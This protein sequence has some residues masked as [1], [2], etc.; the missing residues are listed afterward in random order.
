MVKNKN[1]NKHKH[2]KEFQK[3]DQ[4]SL[5]TP[6]TVS[7]EQ[8]N[9]KLYNIGNT[10]YLNSALQCLL[11]NKLFIKNVREVLDHI[12]GNSHENLRRFNLLH[13]LLDLVENSKKGVAN[14]VSL[15]QMLAGYND[16]FKNNFQHDC[17]E[18]LVTIL[19]IIHEETKNLKLSERLYQQDIQYQKNDKA[20]K[21][22]Y[23][24]KSFKD[25]F[26]YSFVT[27]LFSGQFVSTTFCTE[28]RNENHN[29]EIFNSITLNIPQTKRLSDGKVVSPDIRDSFYQYFKGE[30]LEDRIE[31]DNCPLNHDSTKKRTIMK[32]RLSVWR[33]PRI[34]ILTLKRYSGNNS[35]DNSI[36]EINNIIQ[37]QIES[38]RELLIYDLKQIVNHEGSSPNR[39]HY[40]TVVID[41]DDNWTFVDDDSA[42]SFG[43]RRIKH[44][45]T[46]YILMYVARETN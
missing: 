10:C 11:N 9:I 25:I 27:H 18:C 20:L 36:I 33:F 41:D 2:K 26:G 19:D 46:A 39:G 42:T 7:N 15:K 37:F 24:W 12:R 43:N 34:L 17:H 13:L 21:A 22:N 14:P 44:S 38:T 35:R 45:R 5:N 1:K 4:S 28:C 29:F 40:T 3:M 23:Q 31:C 16:M 6:I 30:L 8:H 32:K